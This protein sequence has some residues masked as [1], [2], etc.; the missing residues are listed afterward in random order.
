MHKNNG[1]DVTTGG[2]ILDNEH[3][4]TSQVG[5][6][7]VGSPPRWPVVGGSM[8]LAEWWAEKW[9]CVENQSGSWGERCGCMA[10]RRRCPCSLLAGR[11]RAARPGPLQDPVLGL[12]S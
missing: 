5:G 11:G 12:V 4:K 9:V 1:S 3:G 7:D 2:Y 10:D 8:A 6:W